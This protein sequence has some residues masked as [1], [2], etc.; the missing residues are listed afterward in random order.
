MINR[1]PPSSSKKWVWHSPLIENF[2]MRSLL[3]LI[4]FTL[5]CSTGIN[6]AEQDQIFKGFRGSLKGTVVQTNGAGW[7]A[8]VK[9]SEITT[10]NG[11]ADD[12]KS[13]I[14][15]N[16]RV[17]SKWLGPSKPDPAW[18]KFYKSLKVGD[19]Y[20][21]KVY[22]QYNNELITAVGGVIPDVKPSN[23]QKKVTTH[24]PPK[25][26]YERDEIKGAQINEQQAFV[27][28]LVD[29]SAAQ[30][31][32]KNNSDS[33][34]PTFPS[35][36]KALKAAYSSLVEGQA[37]RIRIAAGTYREKGPNLRWSKGKASSTPLVIEAIEPGKVT[38]SGAD[39]SKLSQ[40]EDLGDG[41]YKKAWAHDFGTF[42]LGWGSK[43]TIG[44]RS[45]MAFVDGE[46]YQQT[47]IE[48][49]VAI[50]PDKRN[51]FSNAK[52]SYEY[53]GFLDPADHLKTSH[54]GVAEREE[55][56]DAMYIRLPENKRNDDTSIELSVR[57]SL[58]N[59]SH[60]HQLV[61]R[62]INFSKVKNTLKNFGGETPIIFSENND[63]LIENCRFTYNNGHGLRPMNGQRWTLRNVTSNYNGYSG[64][65]ISGL[66]DLLMVDCTTN[67][68]NWRGAWGK[69][70]SWFIGGIKIHNGNGHLIQN[71]Q[72]FGNMCI[73][74][75]YDIHLHYIY[76]EGLRSGLNRGISCF[77]E[78][79]E[80]P[81]LVDQAILGPSLIHTSPTFS[82]SV[83]SDFKV[84]NSIIHGNAKAPLTGEIID[85]A[86]NSKIKE[87]GTVR[88]QWYLRGDPHAK[89]KELYPDMHDIRNSLIT[90][91]SSSQHIFR[92]LNG[93]NRSHPKFKLYT[94]EG[95]NNVW[96]SAKSEKAFSFADEKYKDQTVDLNTW[97]KRV[98]EQKS[99]WLKPD[100]VDADRLDFRLKS[101]NS[102]LTQ[103][104]PKVPFQA[105][106]PDYK[107]FH[108]ELKAF[109]AFSQ[110]TDLH[111]E[112]P[113]KP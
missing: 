32:G 72:S 78:L 106:L 68:N 99:R 19:A 44:H 34:T 22:N 97:G 62:G 40:W 93:T 48:D 39:E 112:E 37:V 9:V 104:H 71:H 94:Y 26:K 24:K 61:L 105:A 55:N 2:T 90:S 54:F 81:F 35:I 102:G 8:V 11:K 91:S 77:L 110:S 82:T 70:Y 101:D 56:G 31:Q 57:S 15:K 85:E 69:C 30:A 60:K 59:F 18:V 33:A 13:M 100:Y 47:L 89:A 23:T 5:I 92:E 103:S 98:R 16:I 25:R 108:D 20:D 65:Q 113:S 28:L 79:S 51:L 4:S 14:G 86:T 7:F 29:P 107:A 6:A 66:D 42:T 45:E 58:M 52:P 63:V 87:Q 3:F 111:L 96:Y 17:K 46:L 88:L 50:Y 1:V 75:W 41:L 36:S 73:G 21:Q 83:V 49:L 12:F 43:F 53:R 80:G 67:F 95:R 10:E 109:I 84:S 38:W 76:I 27:E 74:F 64:I